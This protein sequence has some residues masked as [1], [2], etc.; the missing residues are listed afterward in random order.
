MYGSLLGEMKSDPVQTNKDDDF[1]LQRRPFHWAAK[2][3]LSS[4]TKQSKVGHHKSAFQG[5][6]ALGMGVTV[7]WGGWT[8]VGLQ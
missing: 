2:P 4:E 7:S 6:G 1:V 8:V 5:A 3:K